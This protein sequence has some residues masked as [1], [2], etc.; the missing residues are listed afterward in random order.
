MP[1][2][3][4]SEYTD[5]PAPFLTSDRVGAYLA[6]YDFHVV[7]SHFKGH[8]NGGFGGAIKNMFIGYASS[9]G[10][11]RIHTVGA[12]DTAWLF[13]GAAA[14]DD[15]AQTAPVDAKELY[16]S[17][18]EDLKAAEEKYA[19]YRFE[20]SGIAS[21]VEPD[22]HNK[23]SIELSDEVGGKCYVLCVFNSDEIYDKVSVGDY[24]VCRG[25]YLIASSLFGI[26]LKNSEAAPGE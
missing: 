18:D 12:A 9:A 20:V 2:S 19:Y 10:K 15:L 8:L 21:K 17:F 5:R 4:K 25:N 23:P 1:L 14:Q 3:G 11:K 22:V 16:F 7:L 6:E 24:V 26:V 13:F